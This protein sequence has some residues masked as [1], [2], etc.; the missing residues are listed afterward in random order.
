MRG[1]SNVENRVCVMAGE[2]GQG[3]GTGVRTGLTQTK[4]RKSSIMCLSLLLHAFSA[5]SMTTICFKAR[6]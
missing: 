5:A 6:F 2:G 1:T 4:G 3:D